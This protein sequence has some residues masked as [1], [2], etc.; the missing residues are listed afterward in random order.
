M[1]NKIRIDYNLIIIIGVIVLEIIYYRT[2]YIGAFVLCFLV[3]LVIAGIPS[4]V[5][6]CNVKNSDK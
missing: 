3:L 1:K 4:F 2:A 5:D 6:D